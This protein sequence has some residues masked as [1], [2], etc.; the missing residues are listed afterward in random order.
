MLIVPYAFDQP[1]NACRAVKLGVART[2]AR[3]KY[4]VPLVASEL[5]VLLKSA[6]YLRAAQS[7]AKQIRREDG[8]REA[9]AVIEQYLEA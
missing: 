5:S 3:A 1:D 8:V 6:E 2:V 4:K 9:C 7:L